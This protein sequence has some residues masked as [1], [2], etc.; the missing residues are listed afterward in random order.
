MTLSTIAALFWALVILAALPSVSVVTVT[1]RSAALG[2][3]HGVL[4]ALGILTG[5]VVFILVAIAGLSLLAERFAPLF[6]VIPY[7]GAA[8]LLWLGVGLWR[9]ASLPEQ[10]AAIAPASWFSSW[11]TGLLITLADQKAIL[12]YLGF[13]PAFIDLDAIAGRDLVIILL[14][15]VVAVGGVKLLYARLAAQAQHLI[16]PHQYQWLNRV[17]GTM[18]IAVAVL[19]VVRG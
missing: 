9:R 3:G 8:Y 6:A 12:F 5:D 4:T 7:L 17:A 14:V 2:F 1:A 10:Q 16:K 18:M 19:L 13:F 15:T 11:L